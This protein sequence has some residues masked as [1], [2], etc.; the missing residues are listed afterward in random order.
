MVLSAYTRTG[1][2]RTHTPPAHTK[3]SLLKFGSQ[4]CARPVVRDE[5]WLGGC[6]P[7]RSPTGWMH[8]P[9]H[10]DTEHVE[11]DHGRGE[12]AHVHDV[13]GGRDDRGDD[14]DDQN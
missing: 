14:E 13:G 12:N 8:Q 3:I 6:F 2:A 7:A 9:R 10:R 1:S 5:S 11:R 4:M